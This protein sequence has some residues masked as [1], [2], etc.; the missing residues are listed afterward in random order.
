VLQSTLW[1]KPASFSS[2]LSLFTHNKKPQ[3]IYTL[4]STFVGY[5]S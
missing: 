4:H 1:S 3:L 5:C 2:V